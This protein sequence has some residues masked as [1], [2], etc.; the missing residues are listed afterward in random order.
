[1]NN[2]NFNNYNNDNYSNYS[3]N[4]QNFNMGGNTNQK[5]TNGLA[6]AGF[7]CS[8]LI[9][10]IGLILSI[11]G[12]KKSKELNDGKGLSTAGIIISSIGLFFQVIVIGIWIFIGIMANSYYYW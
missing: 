10:L 2:E 1:M 5:E 9:P 12:L 6:I 4:V 3:N 8:F 11:I 7:V